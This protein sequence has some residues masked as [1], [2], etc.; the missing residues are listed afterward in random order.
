VSTGGSCLTLG[1]GKRSLPTWTAAVGDLAAFANACPK[2]PDRDAVLASDPAILMYTSGRRALQGRDQPDSQA[3]GAVARWLRISAIAPTTCCTLAL[4]FFSWATR[5]GTQLRALGPRAGTRRS[6]RFSAKRLLGRESG[7]RATHGQLVGQDQN[8]MRSGL[9]ARFEQHRVA[10][11]MMCAVAA[12]PIAEVADRFGVQVECL[13]HDRGPRHVDHVHADDRRAQAPR[14]DGRA[15]WPS[16][17]SSATGGRSVPT[18]E[19]GEICVQAVRGG[20]SHAG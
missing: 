13:R 19:V 5:F 6:P 4:P 1:G 2:E 20:H 16:C 11:A 9:A 17:R 18:R 10:Q 12:G 3:H 14:P 15:A 7:G 8:L